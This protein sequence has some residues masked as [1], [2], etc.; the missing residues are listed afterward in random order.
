[1]IGI[2]LIGDSKHNQ[3]DSSGICLLHHLHIDSDIVLIDRGVLKVK[4]EPR[5]INRTGNFKE[6]TRH[7]SSALLINGPK[8]DGPLIKGYLRSRL[9]HYQSGGLGDLSTAAAVL[10][11]IIILCRF[12]VTGL[13]KKRLNRFG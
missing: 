3:R 11:I 6:Y 4:M 7:I 2:S 12:F 13:E 9:C 5:S 1:M 8:T 10:V